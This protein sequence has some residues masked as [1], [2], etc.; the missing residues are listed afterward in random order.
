MRTQ[1]SARLAAGEVMR[2]TPLSLDE[3]HDATMTSFLALIA[4]PSPTPDGDRTFSRSP[5]VAV[6]RV[7]TMSELLQVC[8]CV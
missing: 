1:N 2:E 7:S 6:E 5:F 3:S 4:V 8:V